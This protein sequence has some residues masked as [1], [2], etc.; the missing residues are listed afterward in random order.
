MMQRMKKK[1]WKMI[2]SQRQNLPLKGGRKGEEEEVDGG[3]DW[4]RCH[5]KHLQTVKHY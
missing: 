2:Y 3:K 4:C 5:S 1:K